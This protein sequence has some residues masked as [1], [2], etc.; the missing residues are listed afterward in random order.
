MD[1]LSFL[2]GILGGIIFEKNKGYVFTVYQAEID[3]KIFHRDF[4][5]ISGFK[6]YYEKFLYVLDLY[7]EVFRDR[8]YDFEPSTWEPK[9]L[10]LGANIGMATLRFKKLFPAAKIVCFEPQARAFEL[11]SRNVRKNN[12]RGV[13]L[14]NL[15]VSDHDGEIDF[16]SEPGIGSCP[17]AGV[18]PVSGFTESRVRCVKLSDYITERIDLLKMDIEGSELSVL[19]ELAI[20]GKLQMI[21]R[22]FLEYHPES[23][24]FV[25]IVTLLMNNGLKWRVYSPERVRPVAMPDVCMIYAFREKNTTGYLRFK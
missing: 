13:A 3:N 24:T 25:Q 15:A 2:R 20:A 11:L 21:D 8:L 14:N 4:I 1:F 6:V 22:V 23:D 9:I 16:F 5:M 10:D 12:L 19:S 18:L 17:G 7:K